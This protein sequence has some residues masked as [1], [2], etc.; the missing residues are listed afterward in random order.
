[1]NPARVRLAAAV[2]VAA[3]AVAVAALTG[4]G[5]DGP[6]VV[7]ADERGR[8]LASVRLPEGGR[9]ALQYR[10]SVYQAEVTETFAATD[11][12]F[13]LVAVASP[14]EAVLDYYELEGRRVADHGWRLEPA[15]TPR[16]VTL[17]LVATEVGRRTLVA[18]DRRLP[19]FEPGAGPAHLVL[20]VRR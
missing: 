10:H 5:G 3:L 1:V 19:L 6:A 7:V 16:L 12:G 11:G 14:S 17:P 20:S 13:R 15:A 4:L 18:G 9:F 8:Q 2:L